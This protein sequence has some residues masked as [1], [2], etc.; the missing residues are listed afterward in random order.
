MLDGRDECVARPDLLTPPLFRV[1]QS[2]VS[3]IQFNPVREYHGLG[4][5]SFS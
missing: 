4:A 1:M 2:C 5:P 3:T